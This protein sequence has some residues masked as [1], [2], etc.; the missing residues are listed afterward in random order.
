MNQ[1]ISLPYVIYQ[2]ALMLSTIIGPGT[3]FLM[4]IGAIQVRDNFSC[5]ISIFKEK[6]I[7]VISKAVSVQTKFKMSSILLLADIVQLV[8]YRQLGSDDS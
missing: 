2:G 5:K 7:L 1:S 8:W 6:S 4:I 3:I